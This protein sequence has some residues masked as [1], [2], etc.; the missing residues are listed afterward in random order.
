M[1]ARFHCL[2]ERGT[3]FNDRQDRVD[4]GGSR[5]VQ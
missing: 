3:P 1:R 5:A 4:V 2:G